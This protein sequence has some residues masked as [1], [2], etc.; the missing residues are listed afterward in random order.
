MGCST[1]SRDSAFTSGIRNFDRI[2]GGGLGV[3]E[4]LLIA[5]PPGSGKTTLSFQLAFHAAAAGQ[6]VVYVSTLSEPSAQLLK[7]MRSFAFY[8]ES[9][10]GKRFFLQ[11][12]YPIVKRNIQDVI[13][14]LI[15][16]VDA[17]RAQFLMIDG[18]MTLRELYGE[19]LALRLLINDLST[20]LASRRCTTLVTTSDVPD[21]RGPT[22]SEFTMCDGIVELGQSQHPRQPLRSVRVWKMRGQANSLGPHALT[23]DRDGL[24]IFPRIETQ[25]WPMPESSVG[26]ALD[27]GLRALDALMMG[28]FPRGSVSIVAG[29]PGTGKTQLALQFLLAGARQGQPGML[30]GFRESSAQLMRRAQRFGMDL[31][32][33]LQSGLI[34]VRRHVP[35][36]LQIDVVLGEV[37]AE[38][39]RQGM[40]RLVI[41][42]VLELEDAV[43]AERRRGVLACLAEFLRLH[44]VTTLAMCGTTHAVGPELDF[45]LSP[46]DALAE[47]VLLLRH[48]N[49]AG[50]MARILAVLKMRDAPHD[51]SP[52]QYEIAAH[53]L[54]VWAPADSPPGLLPHVAGMPRKPRVPRVPDPRAPDR[55]TP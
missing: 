2:L 21:M 42:S 41:D 44:D 45:A 23:L 38:I 20:A 12:L 32:T 16:T 10:I 37:F 13:E 14:A 35:A 55:V 31:A 53:G 30:L 46:I 33:P 9:L 49:F 3:G 34:T 17:H 47:N 22:P 52:R 40:P 43:P 36:E 1:P 51:P 11:S 29:A 24:T 48:V 27:S 7:H 18:L 25:G 39:A 8:Q 15:E 54:H 50:A 19:A 26:P 28:G 6:T 4:L 5:G